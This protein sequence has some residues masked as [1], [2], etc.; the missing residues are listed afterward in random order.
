L[1]KV[2]KLKSGV[3]TRNGKRTPEKVSISLDM[4]VLV[5]GL[6]NTISNFAQRIMWFVFIE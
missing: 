6:D 4:D 3:E 1:T 2:E 5:N